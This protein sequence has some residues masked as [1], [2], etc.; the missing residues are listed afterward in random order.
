MIRVAR[1]EDRERIVEICLASF[2]GVSIDEN[3]EQQF[4][5]PKD[6]WKAKKRAAIEDDLKY[7]AWVFVAEEEG[8]VVGFITTRIAGDTGRIANFGIESAYRG[9]GLGK[10]LLAHALDFFRKEGLALARIETMEQNEIGQ[11][12]YPK[13]G[14][15]EVARQIHYAIEL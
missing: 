15:V 7:P 10:K 6:G 12:L 13:M 4:Q 3:I 9:R 1:P 14:F 11:N 5:L 8:Q 2:S